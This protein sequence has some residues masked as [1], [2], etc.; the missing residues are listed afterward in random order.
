MP[1]W[2]NL[3]IPQ[4]L[5]KQGVRDMLRI[6]D[7]RMSG[8]HFGACV[9]HVAP[10]SAVGGPLALVQNGD[11]IEIDIEARKLHLDVSREE[12]ARRKAAWT[13]PE[14]VY[15]RGYVRLYQQHVSQAD[16]GCDLDFLEGAAK[17]PE[18]VI[19]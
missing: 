11:M 5:L 18:P 9:L 12:L 14:R 17:T 15:E 3:P 2:G 4:K 8:T 7:A 13:P 6:S 10:E 16:K 1:E 19:Y